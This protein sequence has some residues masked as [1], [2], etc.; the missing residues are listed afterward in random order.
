MY[1]KNFE[2]VIPA[3]YNSTRLPGKPLIEVCGKTILERTVQQCNE[4]FEMKKIIVLTDSNKILNFCKTK[5]I[6]CKL[7]DQNCNTGTDRISLYT[8]NKDLDFVINVQGDEP[9]IDPNDIDI[10]YKNAIKNHKLIH[11][12]YKKIDND[13]D[14][15]NPSIP[16]VVF[17]NH[18]YLLYMSRT[19]IPSNK[20]SRFVKGFKQVCIYSYPI[21][22]LDLFLKN[23]TKTELE[24]EED[25]EIL[26][27][28]EFGDKIKMVELYGNSFS[29]D[30]MSDLEKL[31]KFLKD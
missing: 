4:V 23:P 9:I 16:K 13:K 3:R 5:K 11:N 1:N 29:I 8:K 2:V 15:F 31:N 17:D 24:K 7:I 10:I 28:L 22:S 6:Q 14:F 25:I 27:F 18:K 26:R 20:K 19:G 12:G 30:T 21:K